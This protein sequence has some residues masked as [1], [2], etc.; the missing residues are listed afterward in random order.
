[1]NANR[2][3]WVGAGIVLAFCAKGIATTSLI[4]TLAVPALAAGSHYL[5]L[6]ALIWMLCACVACAA[7]REPKTTAAGAFARSAAQCTNARNGN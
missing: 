7:M 2:R 4:L 6:F 1:L 5:D 3:Q